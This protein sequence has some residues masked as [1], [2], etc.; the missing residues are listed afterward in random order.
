MTVFIL[1]MKVEILERLFR[2]KYLAEILLDRDG[3]EEED[4][5]HVVPVSDTPPYS[6]MHASRLSPK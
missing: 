2:N 3:E 1:E 5:H 4:V 6:H